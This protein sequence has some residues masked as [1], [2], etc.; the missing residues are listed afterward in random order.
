[1]DGKKKAILI[2]LLMSAGL[3]SAVNATTYVSTL[4]KKEVEQ[5]IEVLDQKNVGP[6]IY[7]A[8]ATK[9]ASDHSA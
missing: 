7:V 4:E 5:M 6:A 9:G 3:Y 8:A 1:M 2:G